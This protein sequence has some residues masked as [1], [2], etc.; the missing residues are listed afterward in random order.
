[1]RLW[2]GLVIL[3]MICGCIDGPAKQSS[4]DCESLTQQDEKDMCYHDL[5]YERGDVSLCGKIYHAGKK[6]DCF[7]MVATVTNKSSF[8]E[9][10]SDSDFRNWCIGSIAISLNDVMICDEIVD[11]NWMK[12]CHATIKGDASIC[13]EINDYRW[14]DT[15]HS[16]VAVATNESS[17]CEKD[18]Q[19]QSLR[20]ECLHEVNKNLKDPGICD[21]ITNQV[22]KDSCYEKSG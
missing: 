9:R 5:A 2:I 4:I 6:D 3:L 1:M 18:I 15:C 22:L 8:C 17:I 7:L 21:K 10:I 16:W 20:D 14:Y 19:N 12:W 11:S 13:K